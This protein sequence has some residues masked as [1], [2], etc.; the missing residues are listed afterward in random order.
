MRLETLRSIQRIFL[1][2]IL[3]AVAI[4]AWSAYQSAQAGEGPQFLQTLVDARPLKG[5]RVGIVAG[6][7]GND[8]GAVCPDGLTEAEVNMAAA[9]AV[10]RDL[11]ALGVTADLL[12]EFDDRL[13]GYRADA[14][15][16]I[17]ADS[18]GVDFSGFKVAS[19]E[20]G[21][22]ASERLAGCL[23]DRYEAAT[24]LARHP[25]TITY[26][27]TK[28]HAFREIASSTPAAIIEIGFLR[29]DREL[30]TQES[31]LVAKGIADGIECF[32]NPQEEEP[33]E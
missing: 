29:G 11:E 12:E 19:L 32:I 18:C 15:V 33:V 10:V 17:H 28:Y 16:S 4:G 8:S 26:D 20:G 2:I 1:I 27:M 22:D 6:H 23:W 3:A 25:N 14:F 30:L 5:V 9:Q 13:D 31:E 24:S 7:S 21:S